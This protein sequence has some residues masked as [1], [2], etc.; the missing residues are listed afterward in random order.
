MVRSSLNNA[1]FGNSLYLYVFTTILNFL[2]FLHTLSR[3]E[4]K[5]KLVQL[6]FSFRY[7]AEEYF[8]FLELMPQQDVE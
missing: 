8:S 1:V 5:V 6:R 7:S 3:I 2:L 4:G